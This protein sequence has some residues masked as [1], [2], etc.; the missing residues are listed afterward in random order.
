MILLTILCAASWNADRW[1]ARSSTWA[2]YSNDFSGTIAADLSK[3]IALQSL[4][5]WHVAPMESFGL[6][7]AA[8]LLLHLEC[9]TRPRWTLEQFLEQLRLII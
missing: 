6:I 9:S 1:H 8:W 4:Y 7:F 3:L 5:V 2:L